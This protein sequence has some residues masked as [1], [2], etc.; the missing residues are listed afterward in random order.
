MEGGR[1]RGF[2]DFSQSSESAR[3]FS[4]GFHQSSL[5]CSYSLLSYKTLD[6]PSTPFF[7]P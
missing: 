6:P 1:V 7:G 3:Y 4:M 2:R 5:S